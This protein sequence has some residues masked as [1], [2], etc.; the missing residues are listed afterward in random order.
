MLVAQ[1]DRLGA[2]VVSRDRAF[3]VYG[4]DVLEA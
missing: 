3:L 1:A 4:T 2:L